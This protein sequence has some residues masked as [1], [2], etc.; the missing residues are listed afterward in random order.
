M[1]TVFFNRVISYIKQFLQI[2]LSV[3]VFDA[4]VTALNIIGM[5]V[6]ILGMFFYVYIKHKKSEQNNQADDVLEFDDAQPILNDFSDKEENDSTGTGGMFEM[7]KLN[8]SND[9]HKSVEQNGKRNGDYNRINN[10]EIGEEN[11][12]DQDE[13]QD[14]SSSDNNFENHYEDI[15]NSTADEQEAW[16]AKS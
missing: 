3:V 16:V 2:G 9:L 1:L 4:K 14:D 7:S 12:V 8:K 6:T 13:D 15:D 10:F 5:F 11:D